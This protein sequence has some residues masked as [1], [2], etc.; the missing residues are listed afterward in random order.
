MAASIQSGC[1]LASIAWLLVLA[2]ISNCKSEDSSGVSEPEAKLLQIREGLSNVVLEISFKSFEID[3]E[4]RK[5]Q[6][7]DLDRHWITRDGWRSDQ[8]RGG[9]GSP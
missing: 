4:E 1:F 2:S 3:N 5:V 7:D 6:S 9:P 8:R